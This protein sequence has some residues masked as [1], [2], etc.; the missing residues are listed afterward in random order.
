MPAA[1]SAARALDW[2]LDW[3]AAAS[4]AVVA[5]PTASVKKAAKKYLRAKH[6]IGHLRRKWKV[7]SSWAGE[8]GG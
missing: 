2:A 1:A 3:A 6:F 8:R 4:E 7:R 5:M